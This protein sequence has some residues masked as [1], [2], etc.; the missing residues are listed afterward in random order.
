MQNDAYDTYSVLIDHINDGD[1]LA[2]IASARDSRNATSLHE[3]C[4]TLKR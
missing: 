3:S 4:E 2:L 1:E